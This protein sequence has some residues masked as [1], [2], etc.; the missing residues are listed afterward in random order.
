[1]MEPEPE[2]ETTNGIEDEQR[3]VQ[4]EEEIAEAQLERA[5]QDKTQEDIEALNREVEIGQRR[6]RKIRFE[7]G[8]PA[9][10]GERRRNDARR[11]GCRRRG[12][13][14]SRIANARTDQNQTRRCHAHAGWSPKGLVTPLR[15]LRLFNLLRLLGRSC[16]S[17]W[18]FSWSIGAFCMRQGKRSDLDEFKAGVRLRPVA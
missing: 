9:E 17:V 10:A 13:T 18:I 12:Y 1:M 4:E 7:V 5:Y 3:L 11:G 8:V 16:R 15:Q 6:E 14:A 2:T